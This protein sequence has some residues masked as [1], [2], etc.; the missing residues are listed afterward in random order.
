M[1]E[2]A[3]RLC[4]N[5]DLKEAIAASSK[6]GTAVVLSAVGCLKK[7]SIRLA[8][9]KTF[10][11]KEGHFEIVSLT[12]TAAH[13]K[14]HLHISVSDEEGR[15]IGGHLKEGSLVDTTAE[16]VLGILEEYDAERVYDETTGY[17]EISFRRL[18]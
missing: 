3:F 8:G 5:D 16:I 1:R 18:S 17:E 14:A 6:E 12:G 11:E 4:L 10:F 15:V 7:I 2:S 13:G 9:A